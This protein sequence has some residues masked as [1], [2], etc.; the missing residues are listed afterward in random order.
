M[1]N[2]LPII[3]D[4]KKSW[5]SALFEI[6]AG[7]FSSNEQVEEKKP[8]VA[9]TDTLMHPGLIEP[10]FTLLSVVN[11]RKSDRSSRLAVSINS[12]SIFTARLTLVSKLSSGSFR[13]FLTKVGEIV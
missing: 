2:L 11:S 9:S 4:L 10:V 12:Q 1:V 13:S 7:I 6:R 5:K 8:P 3:T